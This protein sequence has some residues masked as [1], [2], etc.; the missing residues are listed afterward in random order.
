MGSKRAEEDAGIMEAVEPEQLGPEQNQDPVL[1]RLKQ[2]VEA[3]QWPA[4]GIVAA[5]DPDTK[6]L[7]S[8][9][10]NIRCHGGVLCLQWQAPATQRDILQLLVPR[11]LQLKVLRMVHG[12][13]GAGHFGVAKK[14][15]SLCSRFYWPGCHQDVELYVHC[16]DACTA[17]NGPT[18]HSHAPLQQYQVGAPMERAGVDVLGQFPVTE[19]GNR[20]ILVAMDYFIKWL[21]A[22]AIPDQSAITTAER[23]VTK[24]FY[25]FGAPNE[26]H[27]DQGRNYEA[28]VFS[29][30]CRR[31][32]IKKT[33]T[34]PPHPQSDGLVERFNRTLATQLTNLVDKQQ[35]DRNLHLPLTLWAYRTVVQESTCCTPAALMFGH[36]MHTPVDLVFGPPPELER[37]AGSGVRYFCELKERLQVSHELAREALAGERQKRAYDSPCQGRDF[38][39]GD[40]VWVFCLDRKKG[41]SPKLTSQ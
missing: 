10:V 12:S 39:S 3:G 40:K 29:E 26:L 9:W 6:A 21:E 8:Q 19:Q 11:H 37:P 7:Y 1:G 31:L 5:L 25:R 30:A 35:R 24:M 16:C 28:E 34:T 32:G 38:A 4:W 18:Q 33:R 15:Q 36:E 17:K 23:L 41:Q 20:Y 22:Y 14:L 27:C 13:V 2:W